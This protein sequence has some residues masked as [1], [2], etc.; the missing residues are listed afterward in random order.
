MVDNPPTGNQRIIPYLAYADAPAAVE[1]LCNAYGF[2]EGLLMEMGEGVLGHAELHLGDNVVFLATAFEEMGHASPKDL[3]SVHA[4]VM[5][6][7][8]DVDAHYERAKGAGAEITEAIADQFYGDRTYRT[9][10]LEGHHWTFSQHI[11]DVSPEE[12]KAAAAAMA[13]P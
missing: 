1:F 8:D 3:G 13:Q 7:V 10:D 12:M 6:Y 4:Q 5:V 11:R 9:V 2:E